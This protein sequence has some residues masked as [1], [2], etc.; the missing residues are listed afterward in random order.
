[1]APR[2]KGEYNGK[3]MKRIFL[4]KVYDTAMEGVEEREIFDVF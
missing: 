1:M 4:F 2:K 3:T